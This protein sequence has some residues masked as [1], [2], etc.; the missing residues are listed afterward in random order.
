[1]PPSSWRE[2]SK[3][4]YQV[5]VAKND[6]MI[7]SIV[8]TASFIQRIV[9]KMIH[10]P[11]VNVSVTAHRQFENF[12]RKN[13]FILKSHLGHLFILNSTE[14]TKLLRYERSSIN[15][16]RQ[17]PPLAAASTRLLDPEP[18]QSKYRPFCWPLSS[19][20]CVGIRSFA[21]RTRTRNR[22]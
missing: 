18:L 9:D 21:S 3:N 20:R 17:L 22:H 6:M 16:M 7:R 12:R 1:M 8:A 19:I 10:Y 5:T 11:I 15:G 2:S 4:N 13:N 14:R